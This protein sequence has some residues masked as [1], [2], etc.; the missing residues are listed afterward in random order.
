[1]GTHFCL[2]MAGERGKGQLYP[3]QRWEV[4]P[5]PSL[6]T[7]HLQREV[8]GMLVPTAGCFSRGWV[9][10]PAAGCCRQVFSRAEMPQVSCQNDKTTAPKQ[11]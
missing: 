11:G 1:M 3:S 4:S 10:V 7:E 8:M 9:P 2:K 6:C 5:A